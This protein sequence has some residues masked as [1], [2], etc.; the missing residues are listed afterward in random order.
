MSAINFDDWGDPPAGSQWASP[1]QNDRPEP[2]EPPYRT[3][4][5]P[6][7]EALWAAASE[8]RRVHGRD[9]D[10]PILPI[11][12]LATLRV[13]LAI[14]ALSAEVKALREQVSSHKPVETGS[15]GDGW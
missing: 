15:P 2:P 14:E 5:P 13:A 7:T 6:G 3:P 1:G 9:P 11:Q 4:L 10:D 8:L 12:S